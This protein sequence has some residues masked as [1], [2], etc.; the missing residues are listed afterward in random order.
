MI[1][2]TALSQAI[3]L[4]SGKKSQA[5]KLNS[6]YCFPV[7]VF[8]FPEYNIERDKNS[9]QYSKREEEFHRGASYGR[10]KVIMEA[11]IPWL[12]IRF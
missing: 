11:V 9:I 8:L 10:H 1:F 4:F 5:Y 3:G 7:N 6:Y 12:L 2:L